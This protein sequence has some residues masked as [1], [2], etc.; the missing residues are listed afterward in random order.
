MPERNEPPEGERE[1]MNMS[2]LAASL[3]VTRQWLHRL[4]VTDPEFPPSERAPGSTREV[5]DLRAVRAYYE[6]REKRPG[7]RTDL[8]PKE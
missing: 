3:G 4:R 7:E 5:W 8:K 6:A 1:L 2:R